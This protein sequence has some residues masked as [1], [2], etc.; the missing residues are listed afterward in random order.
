LRDAP[1]LH[2]QHVADAHRIQLPGGGIVTHDELQESLAAHLRG[3]TDRMVWTNTQL[4]PSG[5][6]RPDVFSVAK[7]YAK[8]SADA[9]EIK[10]SVP[11]LRSD[12]TSGKWQSYRQFAHRVWFAFPRGMA[13]FDLIPRECGVILWSDGWRS[14]RKPVAQV[15]DTLPRD[16]WLKLLIES[17]PSEAFGHRKEPRSANEWRA[18]DVAR[19][20]LGDKLADLFRERL[21]AED[22][23]EL[24]TERLNASTAAIDQEVRKRRETALADL[25][26]Q[27]RRCTEAMRD[28]GV[29][30][31]MACDDVTPERLRA[32]MTELRWQLGRGGLRNAVTLLES[33]QSIL[34]KE[35]VAS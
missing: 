13:P 18:Q 24:A 29:A 4:G 33:L 7:S 17:H 22:R 31:G 9:Y 6:A 34:E 12:V 20:L 25:Q 26:Q 10:V 27:E 21:S 32:R 3:A 14:A 19:K 2:A 30:M 11:D 23:Y 8:F 16:A 28:L 5:S 1:R 35:T 15:L